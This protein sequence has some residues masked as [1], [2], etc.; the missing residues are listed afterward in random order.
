MICFWN[1]VL[2][3]FKEVSKRNQSEIIALDSVVL[4]DGTSETFLNILR[5]GVFKR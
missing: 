3:E 2:L 4:L 5:S 1:V